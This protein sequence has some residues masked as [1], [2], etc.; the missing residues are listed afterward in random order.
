[1]RIFLDEYYTQH[2]QSSPYHPQSNKKAER[3]VAIMEQLIIKTENDIHSKEFLDGIS[4][5]R[6]RLR[7]DGFPPTQVVYGRSVRTLLPT[8]T[9]ALGTNQ[10]VEKAREKKVLLDSKRK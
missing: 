1:M 5:L 7:K 9:E 8:L 2:G 4:Q 10:F 3:N 6:H